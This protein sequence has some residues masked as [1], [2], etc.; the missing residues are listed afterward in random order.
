MG[1][2]HSQAPIL[3]RLSKSR[4]IQLCTLTETEALRG[5]LCSGEGNKQQLIWVQYGTL[6]FGLVLGCGDIRE[7]ARAGARELASLSW[8]CFWSGWN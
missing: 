3:C 5:S 8:A 6:E 4:H 1:L 2:S 7:C